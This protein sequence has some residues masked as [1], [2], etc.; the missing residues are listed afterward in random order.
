MKFKYQCSE[1]GS[2]YDLDPALTTCP[3]CQKNQKDNEPLRGVLEVLAEGTLPPSPAD[4]NVA[5]LPVPLEFFPPVP[6]IT[7]ELWQP[8]R[9][10][11]EMKLPGLFIMN[12]GS[13]PTGSFKDRASVLVSA[14][15]KQ[16]GINS[17]VLAST[18]NAGSS[19]AGIGAAAGQKI[20]LFLPET[21]PP[22]K[23]IQALQYGATVY[24]VAGNYDMAYDL[25]LEYSK[26]MGGMNR[27]TAWNPM[28]MEGKKTVSLEIF[29]QLGDKAPDRV[30]VPTG[31]GCILGGVYK[32]LKDLLQFGLIK[33][34]PRI[35]A[36]QAEGSNAL[37]RAW[38]SGSF[39]DSPSSTIADSIS[40]DIPRNGYTALRYLNEFQGEVITVSDE[41]IIQAQTH[42]SSGSG[43]FTE[44]AGAAA[45]AGLVKHRDKISTG[46]TVVVLA[47]GSGLKD[48]ATAMKGIHVPE[49]SI[50]T[51][52]DLRG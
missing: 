37:Y 52:K 20:V 18:G 8:L 35:T 47:T 12:D 14:Y 15:A 28:T 30:I 42:L 2:T 43:L 17:I 5:L 44:P 22:A 32:G 40:V 48:T 51:I 1:C 7:G 21:A 4:R 27:N 34:M 26:I 36:V 31:D 3:S 49:Q 39:D 11:E 13:N 38:K 19:M 9:L 23:M 24:K 45:W 50:H 25:S 16:C 6:R 41:Q 29:S 33:K 46:E 10:C